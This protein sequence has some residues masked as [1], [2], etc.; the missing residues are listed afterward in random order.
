M[1]LIKWLKERNKRRHEWSMKN[2]KRDEEIKY[3][4]NFSDIGFGIVLAIWSL[5]MA[6][7]MVVILLFYHNEVVT[8]VKW[9]LGLL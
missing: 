7:I 4:V 1:S 6:L 5:I 3:H 2:F 9:Y 8:F